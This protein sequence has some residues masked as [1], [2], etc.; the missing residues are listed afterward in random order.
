[1]ASLDQST[2]IAPIKPEAA[3]PSLQTVA[4]VGLVATLPDP[5]TQARAHLVWATAMSATLLFTL[6]LLKWL[7]PVGWP[8]VI[9][10][11][12]A[13]LLDPLVTLMARR[14][15][16]RSITSVVLIGAGLLLVGGLVTLGLPRVLQQAENLPHQIRSGM[17]ILLAKLANI[18][19]K[20]IPGDFEHLLVLARDHVPDILS[21]VL[22][23][24]GT[25]VSTLVGSSLSAVSWMLSSLVV[26]VVGYYLLKGW[27]RV[28][29]HVN[30]LIPT[31]QR[32]LIR[33]HM[34]EVDLVL[35]GFIRGQ[36]TMA[37]VLA[38][39]YTGG[40]TLAGLK[41]AVVIGVITGFG[42]LVPYVGTATGLSLAVISCLV[43]FG[44]DYHLAVVVLVF[45]AIVATDSILITPRIVGDRV[46]LSPAS[47]IISV[48]TCGTVFGFGGV[49]LAVPTVAILKIVGRVVMSVY[50]ESRVYREG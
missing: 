37:V 44:V 46:G 42:N 39:I 31:R 28:V 26:P 33:E 7:P 4:D 6:L 24:A 18:D 12:G 10:V 27:P 8:L 50:K 32:P 43:D 2:A 38:T 48:L 45:I 40:M 5:R 49:L 3:P 47:V 21:G 13:Y 16:S 15:V 17:D 22:P 9:A 41:L 35:N 1:M 29:S 34:K 25:L 20:N 19:R 14:G 23:N 36:L 11:I 30:L